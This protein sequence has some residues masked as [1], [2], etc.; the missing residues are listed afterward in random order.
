MKNSNDTIGNQT[1]DILTCSTNCAPVCPI[2]HCRAVNT[3]QTL[4]DNLLVQ[5][6]RVKNPRP[7]QMG[8][9]SYPEMS[10]MYYHYTLHNISEEHRSC[11]LCGKRL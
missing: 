4:R 8:P 5:S 10:V 6:A 1:S 2:M 3:L 7:L 11:L 9:V